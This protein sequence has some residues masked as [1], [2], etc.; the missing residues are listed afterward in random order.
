ME[1]REFLKN[2]TLGTLGLSIP[3]IRSFGNNFSADYQIPRRTLGKTGEK[4][5]IIGFGG[6]MLNDNPQEF[7]N[8]LVAKA[9]E[10][11]VNYY[12][13][14]PSYGNAEERLGP[15]LKPYR[16]NCFLAC[17][18]GKRD[19]AGAQEEL[20]NSL[21]LLQ[22]DH[23]D[24]YQLH[25]LS[26][27][28]EVEKVFA[29]DGAMQVFVKAKQEGKVKHLGF[30]AHSVDAALLAMKNFDFD[31]ILFPLNFACWNA[32]DF[33]PQVYAEA[34]KRG[35]GILALKA[36]ALTRLADGEEKFYKNVWYKPILDEEIMKMALKFT[37]SKNITAAVPPGKNTLF[38]KAL[39]FMNDFGEITAEET[40]R[41]KE[42]SNVTKPVFMHA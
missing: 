30:S 21:R 35:M 9:Y 42:L 40:N 20:E 2:S 39:E 16:N 29:P 3:A 34:E 12:D 13:V 7:A 32:G 23:F 41:L 31:S 38:L 25:A 5:S 18:T 14:A 37:L 19:A 11:G 24:L 15:A 1:R 8:E 6:I 10:L 17:K 26:S 28:E 27:V 36:M 33:G 22:T 4:L